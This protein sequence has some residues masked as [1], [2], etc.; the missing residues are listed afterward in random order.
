M[1]CASLRGFVEEFLALRV[2][3]GD[4]FR[5]VSVFCAELG[6]TA[7]TC[8]AS[9]YVAFWKNLTFLVSGRRLHVVSVFSAEL[10][11][12]ADTWTALC[13]RRENTPSITSSTKAFGALRCR[14]VV[15]ISLLMV[16]PILHWTAFCRRRENT[17]SI[18]SST[19]AFGALRCR[20]GGENFSPDGAYDSALD[21]CFCAWW[22][23]TAK[24]VD[25][26]VVQLHRCSCGL[27]G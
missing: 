5:I 23:Y 15:K 1:R 13:R 18:T 19:K 10:G 8:S 3:L 14:V 16:L 21:S 22:Q 6:S 26:H 7:D 17:P 9:V 12:P 20:V 25:V 2:F 24:V 27:M 11:S 4:D